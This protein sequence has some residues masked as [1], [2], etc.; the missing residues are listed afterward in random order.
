MNSYPA[1]TATAMTSTEWTDHVTMTGP[2][3]EHDPAPRPKFVAYPI[4]QACIDYRQ[5]IYGRNRDDWPT[6]GGFRQVDVDS[7]DG[8]P[9]GVLIEAARR[10][11]NPV[12][13]EIIDVAFHPWEVRT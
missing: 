4:Y 5:H 6:T 8:V 3:Y 1:G 2:R 11:A 7:L 10:A 13:A 12:D 9:F